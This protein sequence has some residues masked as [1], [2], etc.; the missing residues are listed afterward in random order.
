ML[1]ILA[2]DLS[3][4]RTVLSLKAYYPTNLPFYIE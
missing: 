4:L 1:A 3:V 2:A